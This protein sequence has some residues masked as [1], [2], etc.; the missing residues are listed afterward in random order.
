MS[1]HEISLLNE[2]ALLQ[3]RI[4]KL[5]KEVN[6]HYKADPHDTSD[7]T[8][9]RYTQLGHMM[10]YKETLDKRIKLLKLE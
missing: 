4:T 9:L 10:K 5:E 2:R 7:L 3:M 1:E 6:E 8:I